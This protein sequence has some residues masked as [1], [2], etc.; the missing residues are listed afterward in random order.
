MLRPPDSKVELF[1][2]VMPP[3]AKVLSK[4]LAAVDG[5]LTCCCQCR[6]EVALEAQVM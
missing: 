4:G 3:E 6:Y 1:D 5:C 2:A